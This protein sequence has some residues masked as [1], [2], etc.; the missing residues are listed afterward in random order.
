MLGVHL[1]Y[2]HMFQAQTTDLPSGLLHHPFGQIGPCGAPVWGDRFR[3]RK[4]DRPPAGRH[5]KNVGPARDP[6]ELD[7]ALA[8]VREEAGADAVVGGSGPAK[9][10]GYF[11][12]HSS[13]IGGLTRTHDPPP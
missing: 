1:A 3:G 11:L 13:P 6:R 4:E 10:I 12:L 8:K 9:D 7:E 5:I 2:A